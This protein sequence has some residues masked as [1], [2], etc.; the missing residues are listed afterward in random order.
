[1]LL[2]FF[3]IHPL[4]PLDDDGGTCLVVSSF[5]NQF[6][7]NIPINGTWLQIA[8]LSTTLLVPFSIVV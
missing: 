7:M 3:S 1:V 8:L 5:I 2:N 6:C 4:A